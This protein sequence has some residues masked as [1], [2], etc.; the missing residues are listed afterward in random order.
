MH[1]LILTNIKQLV[2]CTGNSPKHGKDMSDVG[3]TTDD[4][5]V[6]LDGRISQIGSTSEILKKHKAGEYKQIDCSNNAVLPGFVDSHTHFVF[7][8]HRQDEFAKRLEGVSYMDILKAGGGIANTVIPTRNASLDELVAI[9]TE[10]ADTMLS[11]GVTTVEGKSGYGL[12]KDTEL[13]QLRAIRRINENHPIDIVPTFMG[14]HLVPKEFEGDADGYLDFLLKQVLPVVVDENLA[15]FADIFCED[16]VFDIEQSKAYLTEAKKNGLKLKL[17]ADEIV[18]MGGASLGAKLGAVSA[19]H[20][21]MISDEGIK[22]MASSSAIATLLPATA[23]CLKKNYADARKI[24][25]GGCAVALATDY[26]PGSSCT[27]SIPLIIALAALGMN[28]NANEI[29]TA[30]TINGACA[31]DRQDEIGSIEVGKKADIIILDY[32][33]IDYLPYYAGMN[34]VKTVIKNGKIVVGSVE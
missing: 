18:D 33:S 26:N 34:G 4:C 32:P 8:G 21:L 24:I 22:D 25:D 28:M 1:T 29:V 2:T 5:I 27:C 31:V 17:H 6:L 23:F 3:I 13:K 16:G 20:L 12:N 7:A 14:A 10:R 19:D 11:F 30:L 15:E 9:G